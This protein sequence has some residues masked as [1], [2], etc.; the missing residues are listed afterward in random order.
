M[1]IIEKTA[2]GFKTI[3]A[4]FEGCDCEGCSTIRGHALDIQKTT[5]SMATEIFGA[6][7][8]TVVDDE[9]R[10]DVGARLKAAEQHIA[11]ASMMINAI[12]VGARVSET[13][14]WI[15][16]AEKEGSS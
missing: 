3:L 1:D 12:R 11:R 2:E 10:I 14:K 5:A 4:E 15:K 7:L 6:Y 8:G 13:I 16:E 9:G